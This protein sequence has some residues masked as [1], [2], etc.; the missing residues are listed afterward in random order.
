MRPTAAH[1][2]IA[3]LVANGLVSH[4]ITTNIDG[5]HFKAGIPSEK[6]IELHGSLFTEQCTACRRTFRRETI[7]TRADI[8]SLSKGKRA[9]RETGRTCEACGGTLVRTAV[10]MNEDLDAE[11][12]YEAEKAAD[13]AELSIVVGAGFD[14]N[15][16]ARLPF[17][18]AEKVAIVSFEPTRVDNHFAVV[19]AIRGEADSV[20]A[21]LRALF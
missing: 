8:M 21:A 10:G 2:V 13:R 6:L 16:A 14:V 12:F 11:T 4:V 1:E 20:F 18:N 17:R 5:L 9:P 3:W 7:V 19:L 15:P